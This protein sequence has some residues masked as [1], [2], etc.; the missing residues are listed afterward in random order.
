MSKAWAMA[1]M[2]RFLPRWA[3]A[4][5]RGHRSSCPP[6]ERRPRRSRPGWCATRGC[7]CP[8]A[9]AWVAGRLVVAGADLGPGAEVLGGGE[10][11]HVGADLSQDG[12][13]AA[14]ADSQLPSM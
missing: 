7:P 4:D 14:L 5:D 13:G 12:L 6:C 3:S 9:Q 10:A 8:S 1:T 2:A 11:A